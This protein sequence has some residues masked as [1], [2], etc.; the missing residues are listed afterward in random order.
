LCSKVYLVWAE[1]RLENRYVKSWLGFPL[2]LAVRAAALTTKSPTA[3]D[4][5]A[6]Y[7]AAQHPGAVYATTNSGI[8]GHFLPWLRIPSYA[9]IL[10]P[11][12][13]LP[14]ETARVLWL[15]TIA[16]ALALFALLWRGER[17]P[18]ALAL[19][20][21]FPVAFG[22]A[23]GQDTGFI[24][25]IAAAAVL[26]QRN[27]FFLAGLCVAILAFKI[28]FLFAL[29]I[30]FLRSRRA[31]LGIASGVA[32]QLG[33]SF[34]IEPGWV[35]H[36]LAVL[37]SSALDPEPLKMIGIRGLAS[38]LPWPAVA[39]ALGF[40]ALMLWLWRIAA[41]A[42]IINGVSSSLA[43]AL[44]A[45]L[46]CYFYDGVLLIPLLARFASPQSWPGRAA[47]FG[48][49]PLPFLAILLGTT[50]VTALLGGA[51]LILST[52]VVLRQSV[53]IRRAVAPARQPGVCPAAS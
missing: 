31:A 14:Y 23:L 25:L 11:F 44:I 29:A 9:W 50:R 12:G 21:S 43:I 53:A 16:V 40:T 15:I 4:F 1:I 6:F 51:L 3:D 28:T 49:S 32:A 24:L 30:P 26:W 42:P 36:Y 33:L 17:R 13:A 48:L 38:A 18:V 45:A 2:G 22:F 19:C 8:D 35:G 41:D 7:T 10:Q 5:P 39:Y 34:A 47:L 52:C 37:R 46:H 20:W 27:C